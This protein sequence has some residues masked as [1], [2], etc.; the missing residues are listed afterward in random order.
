MSIILKAKIR[1]SL[2]KADSRR[3]RRLS[4]S[5][6]SVVF[7]GKSTPRNLIL[8]Q[9]KIDK[10]SESNKFFASVLTLI[11]DGI[12]EKVIVQAVQRNLINEKVMHID[13][14]RVNE[15][16]KISLIIP[17]KFLNAATCK[18]VKNYGGRIAFHTKVV[19]VR[20]LL[21]DIPEDISVNMDF[22]PVGGVVTISDLIFPEGVVYCSK[23][24]KVV[25]ERIAT[26]VV[27]RTDAQ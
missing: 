11:V 9:N 20:C 19:A 6:P 22:I 24:G 27:K 25:N 7:G 1:N 2:G 14:L 12:E 21:S 17:I 3:L 18:A 16:D 23:K 15:K 4:G 13:F 26:V 5:I 10:I 8:D